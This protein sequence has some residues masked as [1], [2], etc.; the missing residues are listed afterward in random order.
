MLI[1]ND[2]LNLSVVSKLFNKYADGQKNVGNNQQLK[3]MN[4]VKSR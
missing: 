4:S 3:Y 2:R 1:I